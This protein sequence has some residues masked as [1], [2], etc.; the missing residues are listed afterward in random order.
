MGEEDDLDH[1]KWIWVE[2]IRHHGYTSEETITTMTLIEITIPIPA[3]IGMLIPRM[4]AR[5]TQEVMTM[6]ISR[7]VAITISV[8]ITI[9]ISIASATGDR[10]H[11]YDRGRD[12]N[13]NPDRDHGHLVPPKWYTEI[14]GVWKPVRDIHENARDV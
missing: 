10:D 8:R 2:E 11:D 1:A 14:N 5:S 7:I 13:L 12:P 3:V 6:P 4:I 9:A